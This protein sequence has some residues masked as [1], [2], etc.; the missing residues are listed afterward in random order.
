M[1]LSEYD[2]SIQSGGFDPAND[3]QSIGARFLKTLD[4]L[5]EIAPEFSNWLLTDS[6]KLKQLKL[7]DVRDKIG[8]LVEN[9]VSRDDFGEPDPSDGYY[10]AAFNH[11][12][13]SPKTIS[14]SAVTLRGNID[15]TQMCFG[16]KPEGVDASLV[17]YPLFRASMLAIIA[18]WSCEWATATGFKIKLRH[19]PEG[20]AIRVETESFH[21][22]TWFA[23]LCAGRATGLALPPDMITQRTANGG[24]LMIAGEERLDSSNLAQMKHADLLTAIMSERGRPR[25]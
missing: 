19:V 3:P 8:A 18:N 12:A 7:A 23:Y 4:D 6:V 5:S 24:L 25:R 14:F 13:A 16:G 11:P 2:Y 10:M 21:H 9:N 17:N 1:V 22:P 20:P 15:T